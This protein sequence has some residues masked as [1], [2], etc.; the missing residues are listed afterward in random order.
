MLGEG[1]PATRQL[2]RRLGRRRAD[3]VISRASRSS[4]TVL[5]TYRLSR[6]DAIERRAYAIAWIVGLVCAAI[7]IFDGSITRVVLSLFAS[8][9]FLE[10]LFETFDATIDDVGVCEFRS[11]L[12]RKQI[13]AHQVRSIRGGPSDDP[14]ESN[15]IFIRYDRGRVSLPGENFV[16]LVQ[17][18]LALNTEIDLDLADG[19]FRRMVDPPPSSHEHLSSADPIGDLRKNLQREQLL[20]RIGRVV[21]FL[22]FWFLLSFVLLCLSPVVLAEPL[23][24]PLAAGIGGV[25][26]CALLL[27]R[28]SKTFKRLTR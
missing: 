28:R 3:Q 23:A 2:G 25:A 6:R 19:W 20:E 21:E 13:R 15:D 26:T 12:R 16:G 7:F 17:D 27:L 14:E 1:A 11:L 9:L 22:S 24:L 8:W 10:L 4:E 18:L 5:R